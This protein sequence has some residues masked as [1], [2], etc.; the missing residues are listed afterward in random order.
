MSDINAIL[1]IAYRDFL[2]LIR[3]KQRMIFSLIFP[4]IFVAALGGSL[5]AN[6]AQDVGYNLLTFVFIGIIGQ[7]LFQ[8]TASG[9]ISLIEDRENDFSQEIFVSPISRYSIITGKVLGESL[10][11][12]VQLISIIIMG[13]VIG[14]PIILPNLL[15]ILPFCL[16]VCLLGGSF[17][18]F[19]LSNL[20]SQRSANQVFP[21]IMFPQFFLSGVFTPIKNLPI[22]LFIL[23]RISPMTYAVDLVRGIYYKGMP[24]YSKVV[25]HP[26]VFNI[27]VL[28]AM[29]TVFISVGTYF[30]IKNE[31][32]R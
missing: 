16:L 2:K 19:V 8:T 5:N 29:V 24:E 6:L 32:N 21:F 13:F 4:L 18:I 25:L 17:G 1:T 22:V 12:L 31:R 20:S 15:M 7:T 9:V 26:A 23:S 30:F 3:D 28:V 11:G 14:V 10:V 27:L